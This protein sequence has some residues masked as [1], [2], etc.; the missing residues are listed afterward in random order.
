MAALLE[1]IFL[2]LG[3]FFALPKSSFKDNRLKIHTHSNST[4][5][6]I[7]APLNDSNVS[8]TPPKK[9]PTPFNVF[10]EPVRIATH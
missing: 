6:T 9:K 4:A 10:L 8:N 7:I 2:N 1:K 5:I 3:L